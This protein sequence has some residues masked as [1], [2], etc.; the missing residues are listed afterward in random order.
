[1]DGTPR[2]GPGG[3]PATPQANRSPGA[4]S[5]GATFTPTRP[6]VRS[7]LPQ[8]PK[9]PDQSSSG[10]L[11]P[12]HVMDPAQQRFYAV[13][14]Y[15]L[16]LA[17]KLYDFYTLTLDE[18]TS[19][20]EFL[21]WSFIDMVFVFGLPLFEI[22]WV[23]WGNI[24]AAL[25]FILHMGIN[26]MLMFQVGIPIQS[27][28][29]SLG[30]Y[31]YSRELAISERSVKPRAIL[32]NESL[33]LGKQIINILPE[34]S[35]ILNP[36]KDSFCLNSSVTHLD[37][38]IIVNQTNP[39]AIELL[40]I[41]IETNHNE[42]ILISKSECKSMMK[43]ARKAQ[44]PKDSTSPL[45]LHYNIKK[46]GVYLLK[47]IVDESNLEVRPRPSSA[48][49]VACPR[50][51]IR[52]TG[53]NRCRNDLSDVALELEGVP[54]L[55]LKYRTSIGGRSRDAE[56]QGLT[57][58]SYNSPLSKHTSQALI[59][60]TREDVSWAQPQ[61]VTVSLNETL[62]E[63]GSW[64][65]IVEE[66]TDALGNH[67]S[68]LAHDEEE[69]PKHKT[70][71]M[72]S[73][74]VHER[75]NVVLTDCNAQS[76][77]RIAKGRV[78]RLPVKYGSTGKHAINAPHIIEYLFTPEADL[79]PDGSHSLSAMLKKETMRT[80]R[81]QPV[82]AAS[83]LYTLKS[84]STEFC[85]GE[86][87]EPASCLLQNPP[88]PELSLSRE[89]IVD[90]CAG[91]PIGM[92]VSLDLIG[93]PPFYIKYQQQRAGERPSRP[94]EIEVQTLRS[95]L[96]LTPKEAG[97]YTYTFL[98][99]RDWVYEERPLHNL[100]LVQDVKPSA[101]AHFI[102]ADGVKQ[103]CID[104]TVE[105][106]VGLRGEGP[107]TLEYELVHNGKRQK[108]SVVVE[109]EHY[110]IKTDKLRNGGEYILSLASITDRLGCKEVLKAESRVN[111][112]HERPKAYFGQ[113]D[114]KQA[115]MALEGKAVEL[116]LRLTGSGP[117]RLEYENLDTKAVKKV[118]IA[119]A[120]SKLRIDTS[121]TYQ[122]LSVRDRV[123]PG[124]VD[125]K[126]GQFT[127]GWI[128]RPR[129]MVPESP[130]MVLKDGQ[131]IREE[132]CE[133]EEDSFD[134]TLNGSPPFELAYEQQ[135]RD[136][137]SGKAA[138]L[139]RK[140]I[141]APGGT[142]SIRAETAQAG[143]YQYKFVQLADGKY[144]HSSRHFTPVTI[145]QTVNPRPS[146]RFDHPGK[147]Y[148]FCSRE[149][150]GEEVIPIT[151][152]GVPPFYLEVE[153]K[154]YGTPKP[155]VSV[156]KS[157]NT[158][159]YNLKIEHRKLSLGHSTISIRK[160][161]DARGCTYKPPPGGPRVQ[162]S[163]HDAPTATPLEDRTDFCVGE[164]LSFAL[165]GQV[166]FTV[167]YTFEDKERKASNPG[168][169]FRR[170]AELP[171]TFTLTGLKDSASDCIATLDLTKR[172]HPIPSVRLS[173]GQVT[174]VDIHEGS[175]ADLEF[176]FWGTPPFEFTYTR[177]T[178]EQKGRKSKV[179]EIR[180]EISH[181]HFMS[182]PVQE[183]GT[184]EVVSIKDRWCSYA[185]QI[186]GIDV[187]KGA[188]GQKLLQY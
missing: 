46:T 109:D 71:P 42:T 30:A 18:E 188:S 23:E 170:L 44:K 138:A 179:L 146:A 48:V 39:T 58:E 52:Q 149:A 103:V 105:F 20:W 57:P 1:M 112:R 165:G 16:L 137:K 164:R 147:T 9:V 140:E 62:G 31:L 107:F 25:L 142:G 43:K 101:S 94:E 136:K 168:T 41:D 53:Q 36:N 77:L 158:N 111:V 6:N 172:I 72:H 184:Y 162:I 110:T 19:A 135:F 161:R 152:E 120:N 7:P 97:H 133:G 61:K 15:G 99:I 126:T 122:L 68:F 66:V 74:T 86:V 187:G 176:Q 169:T 117:W 88:E 51:R 108:R 34:G 128:P 96:E 2:R 64:A 49:V 119:Q 81:D 114:G 182:I 22:P 54:P 155:D 14:L 3:F 84:V 154:H 75:P 70:A 185:K 93:S 50:A 17:W 5:A 13:G 129:I 38:P 85:Q 118:D 102:E 150:D 166:P 12:T 32:F 33:I 76:P 78:I 153:I 177:S 4:R 180:T 82:I 106:D 132:V 178:N 174:K 24:T 157:I 95:T 141:R 123:C 130:S 87:L 139:K 47:K 145:L 148:S 167:F 156:H 79:L 175:G 80:N 11:I 186:E 45:E 91:N 89:D 69:K 125:E 59:R 73:F 127:V 90:K 171:G 40:R 134:I 113:I 83:G 35:A 55:R 131:Y 60:A 28:I 65:Y 144:D 104:D 116:P 181:E 115:V 183:E 56:L 63:S 27:W 151:L 173:G 100:K 121:G 143:T 124:F 10:P 92:R 26:A 98:S 67:V 21:K 163:V 160:I 37:L 159:K 8:V 29:Y